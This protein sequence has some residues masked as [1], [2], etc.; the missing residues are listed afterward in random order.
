MKWKNGIMRVFRGGLLCM[1]ELFDLK[2]E[3][4]IKKWSIPNESIER[5]VTKVRSFA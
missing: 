2:K 4:K 1:V 5:M 3:G